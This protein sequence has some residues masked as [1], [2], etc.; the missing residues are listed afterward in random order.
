MLPMHKLSYANGWAGTQLPF[1]DWHRVL[2][3]LG[4]A[5]LACES[6]RIEVAIID[7]VAVAPRPIRQY[8]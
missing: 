5:K 1:L 4:M 8:L 7:H 6:P 2:A 3:S